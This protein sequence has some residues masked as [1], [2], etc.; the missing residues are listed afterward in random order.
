MTELPLRVQARAVVINDL[1]RVLLIRHEDRV[2]ADPLQPERLAYWVVPGGKLEE[3]E[4]LVECAARET[5]EETGISGLTLVREL[6]LIRKPLMYKE[7]MRMM[8]AHYFLFRCVGPQEPCL[9]DPS[10]N[11]TH[12][13]WWSLEEIKSSTDSFLPENL[14]ASLQDFVRMAWLPSAR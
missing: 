2:P 3:G 11:I 14:F 13:R 4:N 5:E 10:E 12:A 8:V 6:P 7:G 1:G 9:N